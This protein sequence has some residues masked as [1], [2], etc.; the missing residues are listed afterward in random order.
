MD[1]FPM[2]EALREPVSTYAGDID[3]LF[4]MVTL[5]VG[6]WFVLT[7]GMFFYLMFRF[8]AKPGVPAQYITGKEKHLK[9]WITIPHWLII[10]C[11]IFVIF[12]AIQ[13]WYNVKQFIPEEDNMLD[14]EIVAQQ[15][16]WTFRHP[17]IDNVLYTDDDIR[18]T[19]ELTVEEGRVVRF[20]LKSTDVLHDFSVPVLRLK[21]DAL[22]GRVIK[23]WFK[24]I[25]T[26]TY[27]IQCAE[28]CG[29]GHGIMGAKI[30]IQ[31]KED[32]AAWIKE[33]SQH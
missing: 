16:A 5:V 2:I 23:G 4:T 9:R 33:Q 25:K 20:D 28:M 29:I 31:S 14:I 19:D 6:F 12:F 27:D 10:F 17:G 11:D 13:V 24:A 26:G 7:E 18:S 32:H 15:W 30:F 22:P 8:R 3:W 1:Y 21:Q